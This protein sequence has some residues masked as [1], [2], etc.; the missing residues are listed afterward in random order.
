MLS[1]W[2][3]LGLG[4]CSDV[5]ETSEATSQGFYHVLEPAGTFGLSL[6]NN[7]CNAGLSGGLHHN[8]DFRNLLKKKKKRHHIRWEYSTVCFSLPTA[9]Q[10]L[11]NSTSHNLFLFYA[12]IDVPSQFCHFYSHRLF[13]QP[14]KRLKL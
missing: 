11:K 5:S 13:G 1:L 8:W 12:V 14:I 6:H 2:R 3:S 9:Q 7:N 10:T 4:G